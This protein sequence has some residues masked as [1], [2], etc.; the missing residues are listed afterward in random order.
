MSSA[1]RTLRLA[2]ACLPALGILLTR[3]FYVSHSVTAGKDMKVP[4]FQFS[5]QLTCFVCRPANGAVAMSNPLKKAAASLGLE[6]L[7]N[8]RRELRS[9]FL[10]VAKRTHPDSRRGVT[11]STRTTTAAGRDQPTSSST[12]MAALA[13]SYRVLADLYDKNTGVIAPHAASMFAHGGGTSTTTASA[14]GFGM[15]AEDCKHC[16][17]PLRQMEQVGKMWLPWL[18][19]RP[20][21]ALR[22]EDAE[23]PAWIKAAERCVSSAKQAS[24]NSIAAVR[25]I[26]TGD[27]APP[28]K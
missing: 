2:A 22:S 4:F 7:P 10:G 8:T 14:A 27:E 21:S 5:P 18:K 3:R 19:D 20:K 12:D 1:Y 17:V 11:T 13:E 15:A 28:P 16:E 23:T 6:V 26:V 25:F 9:A 24:R